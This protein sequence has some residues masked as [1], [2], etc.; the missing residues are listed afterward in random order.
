[1]LLLHMAGETLFK[2]GLQ[3]QMSR[4]SAACGGSDPTHCDKH[5]NDINK[6]I[7][8]DCDGWPEM[9][10]FQLAACRYGADGFGASAACDLSVFR[11][12]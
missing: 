10:A 8:L 1:M 11:L 9:P 4:K 12:H 7:R 6:V 3:G 5:C 2:Y